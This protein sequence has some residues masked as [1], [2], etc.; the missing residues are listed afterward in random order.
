MRR[1]FVFALFHSSLVASVAAQDRFA[2]PIPTSDVSVL[3]EDFA[4]IPD[5]SSRQP[6]RLSLLTP[7][8]TGRLF[9]ND[10]R[11]PLYAID[12]TGSQ[13]SEYLDLRDFREL[14]ITSTSEAGFQSFAFHPDFANTGADGFGR[15]YTIHSSTSTN[16]PPDF[17]PGGSTSF[18]TLLLEWQTN[19]PA[20]SVFTPADAA[21]PYREVLRF[22]QPFG[23]HNAG[24]IAFNPTVGP[25][26]GDYGNLYIALGD[27][28]SGGDPQEN[29]QDPSNP[30]AALLRV[31]PRGSD[32]INGQYGIVS[33]NVLAADGD[34]GTLGE[35]YSYGLRNPQRFG[36]D[37]AT[38]DMF[39]ADIGQSVIE[40]INLGENG[41]NF[42]WDDREGSFR[43]E[44]NNTAGLI[45]PVAEYD[46][47]NVVSDPPTN[48]GSRAITVGEVARGTGISGLDGML[49]LSDFPTGLI[50]TLDV[51]NDPLD[52]G[53]DGLFELQPLDRDL[54]PVRLLE[55]IN[56]TR[57]DRG[58]GSVTR[59]DLRFGINTP[60]EVY[61][62]N[63]HDGIVRHLS[64]VP[65]S[66]LAGDFNLDSVVDLFD[67]DLLGT[68]IAAGTNG[69]LFD[70]TEDGLVNEDDL[71]LFL[72]GGVI[73]DGNKLNGDA[74]FN[75]QVDFADFVVLSDHY[76]EAGKKWSEG[77]FDASGSVQFPDFVI[78]A[79]NFGNS[80]MVAIPEPPTSMHAAF[81]LLSLAVTC[82]LRRDRGRHPR[83]PK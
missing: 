26:N 66:T 65:G 79:N 24:L 78:L 14:R 32:G 23:N 15:F 51:D 76:G 2:T 44:S 73:S 40:E 36:W 35:I 83:N 63:K 17:D 53:Q 54:Q 58:L 3:I 16:S 5:S 52:G 27:G 57:A 74:D 7:D 59:A 81:V 13:V 77:D 34:A 10:Q 4:T 48:I 1:L 12:S 8:P 72:G 80:V 56:E 6:P 21:Q 38:G 70:L 50:F 55:L 75:G 68:E 9:V 45:D 39:I 71:G 46:H 43:F 42:G 20:E 31:D 37:T 18:H 25:T 49:L 41:G 33:D 28:G 61:I 22:K 67:I 69:H 30:F 64:V 47:T 62:L 29:G 11:G 19:T 60:G 82:R